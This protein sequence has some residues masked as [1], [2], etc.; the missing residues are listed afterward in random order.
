MITILRLSGCALAGLVS[1]CGASFGSPVA[2]GVYDENVTQPNNVD[3]TAIGSG[4]S[5]AAFQAAIPGAFADGRGGV[6]NCD[7]FTGDR[8]YTYAGGVK[9]FFLFEAL[10]STYG[11]GAPG[12]ESTPVSDGGAFAGSP[13]D[14]HGVA[15]NVS[16]TGAVPG[17][18]I[19][20]IGLTVLSKSRSGVPVDFGTVTATALLSGGG[21]VSAGRIINEGIGLGDT[22]FGLVAPAGQSITQVQ[23]R[24]NSTSP[25]QSFMWVDDIGFITRPI[26]EPASLA[27][28]AILAAAAWRSMR[29]GLR[30]SVTD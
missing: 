3:F 11:V 13:P 5:F 6:V 1:A 7:T 19:Y 25:F 9:E 4:V 27:P 26:P 10:G 24:N 8:G 20:Q 14:F 30:T 22:F 18:A 23:V 12:I 16:L 28:G 2:V 21:T 17:E 15:W 29:R